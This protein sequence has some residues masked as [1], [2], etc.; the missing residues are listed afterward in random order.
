MAYSARDRETRRPHGGV[1]RERRAVIGIR[2]GVVEAA[3]EVRRP[4]AGHERRGACARGERGLDVAECRL[5][6]P[7]H[8]ANPRAC[9]VPFR[10][11]RQA[12]RAVEQLL[13]RRTVE[14]LGRPRRRL[15]ER[16][17]GQ[18]GV[19]PEMRVVG[20]GQGIGPGSGEQDPS[21]LPMQER[22]AG[23]R[24]GVGQ[25]VAH[26][27]VTKGVTLPG[28]VEQT[29]RASEVEVGDER[30]GPHAQNTRE[31]IDVDRCAEHRGGRDRG[32]CV[33]EQRRHIGDRVDERLGQRCTGCGRRE[34]GEKERVTT[35]PG[36]QGGA[37]LSPHERH[38]FVEGEWAE[39]NRHTCRDRRS[40]ARSTG[41]HH[42]QTATPPREVD[43]QVGS[44][45]AGQMD[46]VDREHHRGVCREATEH[47]VERLE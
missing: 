12:Q 24:S 39:G 10:R 33:A 44:R 28:V 14:A 42:E 9:Q 38:R 4:R 41:R 11:V 15:F 22:G 20:H 45:C 1:A 30:Q 3:G 8:R 46:V 16:V 43:E 7:S 27:G 23:R 17:C 5:V 25:R 35:R 29:T 37:A 2:P 18:F 6:I 26:E 34:L 32:P 47:G 21:C 13:R 31:N 19:A 36:V 40:C